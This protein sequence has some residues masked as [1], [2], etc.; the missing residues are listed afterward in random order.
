MEELPSCGTGL[1]GRARFVGRELV[2]LWR[3]L[4]GKPADGRGSGARPSGA[5]SSGAERTSGDATQEPRA[6]R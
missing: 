5:Q 4:R 6:D 3:E 2:D 1:T